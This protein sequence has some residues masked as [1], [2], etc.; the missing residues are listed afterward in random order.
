MNDLGN[1]DAVPVPEGASMI[2]Q[3]ADAHRHGSGRLRRSDGGAAPAPLTALNRERTHDQ[4]QDDAHRPPR[5]PD[6]VVQG[7]DDLQPLVRAARHRRRR[8]ADGRASPRTTRR[9][10]SSSSSSPTSA[11]RCHHAAQGHDGRPAR[12]GRRPRSQVAGSCN[13]VLL[14]AGRPLARRHVRRRGLRARRRSARAAR[15][16]ARARSSSARGGVGSA[17]AAS[18][19]AAGVGRARRSSTPTPPSAEALA[20][21]LRTHYPALDGRDRLQ[22]PAPAST[23]SSTRRRSA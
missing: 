1:P 20:G 10:C 17:I 8:R 5:L 2:G 23:S 16:R 15:S 4:R 14:R 6:R 11:A 18:L 7:A 19:A 3:R 21:R 9:S 12:R 13:A 22:R